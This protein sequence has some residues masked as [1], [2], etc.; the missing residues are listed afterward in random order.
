MPG[1]FDFCP[2]SRVIEE[3]APDEPGVTDMNGWTFAPKAKT[4]YR[5]QFKVTLHGLRWRMGTN[6]LDITTGPETNAGRLRNFYVQNRMSGRFTLQHEYLG[7][8]TCRFAKPVSIPA[9][10]TNSNGLV[11][12]FEVML[13]WHNPPWS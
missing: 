7:L 13:E 8:I 10:I 12:A 6:A 1:T 2:N 11:D 4:P 9:A 3:L 5:P